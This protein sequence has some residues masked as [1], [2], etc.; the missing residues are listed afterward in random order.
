M[1]LKM[2]QVIKQFFEMRCCV[3][4]KNKSFS[5]AANSNDMH[6]DTNISVRGQH[7]QMISAK[8]RHVQE[9]IRLK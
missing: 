4:F 2:N 6:A 9:Q 7:E 8:R 3:F 5:T 1:Y